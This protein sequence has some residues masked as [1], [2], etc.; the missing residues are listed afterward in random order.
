MRLSEPFLAQ[1][2]QYE[3]ERRSLL[4][5]LRDG[6]H[7]L[8]AAAASHTGL[9]YARTR[10]L[11]LKMKLKKREQRS[12]A[13]WGW[14]ILLWPFGK[15]KE[16]E[17]YKSNSTLPIKAGLAAMIAGLLCFAPG[18]LSVFN[19]NGM[20]GVITV[21]IVLEA[22]VGLTFSKGELE[23]TKCTLTLSN[24]LLLLLCAVCLNWNVFVSNFE[25]GGESV[26]LQKDMKVCHRV[27][28]SGLECT[29][30]TLTLPNGFLLLLRVNC[31]SRK[32]LVSDIECGEESVHFQKNWRV[33]HTM[34][35]F[36]LVC[37]VHPHFAKWFPAVARSR[38]PVSR[39]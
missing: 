34:P 14:G 4:R 33:C 2:S 27:P 6:R 36:G 21:D 28:D 16:L 23:C 8:L 26:H 15:L 9:S 35:V 11:L 39:C 37:N 30:C 12:G 31:S 22:N 25:F 17:Q 13:S 10:S 19:K 32:V 3:K 1:N 29:K 20:W 18:F 38:L 5:R 24:G 7:G